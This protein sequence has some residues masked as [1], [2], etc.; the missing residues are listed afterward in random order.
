[1]NP[2]MQD[3]D[4]EALD[5]IFEKINPSYV[6]EWGTGG[7]TI[8]FPKKHPEI[9]TWESIENNKEWFDNIKNAETQDNVK[10]VYRTKTFCT[11]YAITSSVKKADFILIDGQFRKECMELCA[12][13]CKKDAIVA[14]H[15]SG[16]LAY[17][18]WF[19]LFPFAK[20]ITNG[21]VPDG[22]G[23]YKRDGLTVFSKISIPWSEK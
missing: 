9:Q 19:S 4:I 14:L 21:R 17:H 7:S 16:R 13:E 3:I 12:R 11:G 18:K 10:L 8:Y 1:M 2:Y 20:R 5:V 15:D 22:M 23:G 6:L